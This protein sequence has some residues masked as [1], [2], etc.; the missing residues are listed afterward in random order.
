LPLDG[1]GVSL[2]ALIAAIFPDLEAAPV[3][4]SLVTMGA[5]RKRAGLYECRVRHLVFKGA[6]AYW[7]ALISLHGLIQT[8]ERNLR[9]HSTALEQSAISA[10]LPTR[11]RA[12]V[13]AI[14]QRRGLPVL[15]GLDAEL[16]RR[17]REAPS[18]EGRAFAG[19]GMYTIDIPLSGPTPRSSRRRPRK[20][21]KRR[22]RERS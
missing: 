2:R 4:R 22:A 16:R 17:A 7:R 15:H 11:D 19:F 5:I 14:A 13:G 3:I 21:S 20:P 18:H 9:G 1:P 8:M 12:E 6:E 10:R